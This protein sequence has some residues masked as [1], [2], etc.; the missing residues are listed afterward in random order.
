M[1]VTISLPQTSIAWKFV[2]AV[3]Q[4]IMCMHGVKKGFACGRLAARAVLLRCDDCCDDPI[5][6][7]EAATAKGDES[8]AWRLEHV[9]RIMKQG[10]LLP[11]DTGWV[12][13]DQKAHRSC[14]TA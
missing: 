10:G 1:S 14:I 5:R 11:A 9:A 12:L 3:N 13:P 7:L 6:V 4:A 2:E 8:A